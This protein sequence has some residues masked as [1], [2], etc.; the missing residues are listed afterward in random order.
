MELATNDVHDV[1]VRVDDELDVKWVKMV[2]VADDEYVEWL[3]GIRMN[4]RH[5]CLNLVHMR[6]SHAFANDSD[7]IHLPAKP[8]VIL[9]Y[10]DLAHVERLKIELKL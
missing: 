9:A 8:N 4:G 3:D 1:P 6:P 5:P 7:V 10:E 2:T